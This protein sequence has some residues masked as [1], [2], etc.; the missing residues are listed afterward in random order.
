MGYDE[1]NIDWELHMYVADRE[2]Y[3][4]E[5]DPEED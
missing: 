1:Q 4:F 3:Y 2:R 5:E